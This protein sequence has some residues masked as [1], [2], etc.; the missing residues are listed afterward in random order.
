MANTDEEE[1]DAT[2]DN[3][4]DDDFNFFIY[5]CN[6]SKLKILKLHKEIYC[7]VEQFKCN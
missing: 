7:Y 4:N 1:K 5:H 3:Y 2:E 6:K